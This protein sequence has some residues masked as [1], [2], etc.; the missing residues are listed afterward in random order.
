MKIS[1]PAIQAA[2]IAWLVGAS[3]IYLLQFHS[4]LGPI[5]AALGLS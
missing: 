5:V 3:A 4:L 2:L 1:D